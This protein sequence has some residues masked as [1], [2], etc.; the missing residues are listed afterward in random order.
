M[1]WWS[2]YLAC[3]SSLSRQKDK[4][5]PVLKSLGLVISLMRSPRKNPA[6]WRMNKSNHCF[7]Q[8]KKEESHNTNLGTHSKFPNKTR[9]KFFWLSIST[10]LIQRICCKLFYGLYIHS[11]TIIRQNQETEGW[12]TTTQKQ[13]D[14]N[15]SSC[16]IFGTGLN[17]V[18]YVLCYRIN[19]S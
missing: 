10:F 5:S 4:H 17:G 1:A 13:S 18:I 15:R 6:C 2:S 11:N 19:R 14:P 3:S 7:K 8:K 12:R 16:F 9:I